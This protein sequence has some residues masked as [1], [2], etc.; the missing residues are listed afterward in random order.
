[1]IS[2]EMKKAGRDILFQQP[3]SMH[4]YTH[5]MADKCVEDIYEA[6]QKEKLKQGLAAYWTKVAEDKEHYSNR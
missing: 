4:L 2:K 1:M 3:G 5:A 6:M